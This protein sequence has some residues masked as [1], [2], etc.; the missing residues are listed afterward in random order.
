VLAAL[1]AF[2]IGIWDHAHDKPLS[3]FVFVALSVPLF[4][5]GACRAWLKECL[6]LDPKLTIGDAAYY[7]HNSPGLTHC[8]R[9]PIGNRSEVQTIK[10]VGVQLID[11]QPKPEY[12]PWGASLP[13]QWKDSLKPQGSTERFERYRD[14]RAGN[15]EEVDFVQAMQGAST[16]TVNHS[17]DRISEHT[18]PLPQTNYRMTVEAKGEDVPPE[19]A[20]FEVWM[21]EHGVLQCVSLGSD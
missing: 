3:A 7:T 16:I 6:K 15:P 9:L 18:I 13:L 19:R 11:I 20:V 1:L 8:Y 21:N 10:K 14:V 17:V 5:F 4:W 12:Y 2:G